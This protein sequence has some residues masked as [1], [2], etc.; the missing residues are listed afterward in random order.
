[1]GAVLLP[2]ATAIAVLRHRLYDLDLVV[3]R[4]LVYAALTALVVGGYVGIVT[5]IEALFVRPGR[6][7]SLVAAGVVALAF[8][9]ARDR[10][11]RRVNRLMFGQRD[12]PYGVLSALGRRLESAGDPDQLLPAVVESV[13]QALRLPGAAVEL[14]DH[15]QS[16]IVATQ[17]VLGD[18]P[19]RFPLL[20]RDQVLGSLV[21]APR[22]RG[23]RLSP[24]DRRL[25]EDVARQTA[26]AAHAVVLNADLRRSRER[27]RSA[28]EEERRRIRRDLHD[29]LGPSLATVVV[30]LDQAR[31][32]SVTDPDATLDLLIDLKAQTQQAI[33]DIRALVYDLRPPA[34][35]ELG[36]VA[37]VRE[38]AGRCSNGTGGKRLEVKVEAPDE[39]PPLPAAVE[40]A[41]FRVLQEALTN[42][43]RHAEA[44]SCSI[45]LHVDAGALCLEVTDDGRGVAAGSRTG[46]GLSSMGERAEELGGQLL[47][48]SGPSGGTTV[49]ARL[50]LQ[51]S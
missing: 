39:L 21:V 4:T 6:G 17:G 34:L 16:R 15:D 46:V 19:E 3:N 29:G 38:H 43:V 51:Q 32:S 9:P 26:V 1:M 37:A 33:A 48:Q 7:G 11:Q 13:T 41:A 45:L 27:L 12:D 36:L 50:P 40:V 47:V 31:N 18:E 2:V 25:L 8:Q 49:R 30:G 42:V 28:L 23:E 22:Q 44:T 5:A 10:V 20:H 35:D 14:I 24:A